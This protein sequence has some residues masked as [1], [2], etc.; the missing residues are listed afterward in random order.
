[1]LRVVTFPLS[2]LVLGLGFVLIVLRRDH[3]ALH[4]LVAGTTVVYSWEARA[5]QLAFLTRRPGRR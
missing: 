3:R 1:V 2:F 5:S 4:D